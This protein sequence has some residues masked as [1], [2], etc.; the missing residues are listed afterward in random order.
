[1]IPTHMVR[2][3]PSVHVPIAKHD[4]ARGP[5]VIPDSPNMRGERWPGC[6]VDQPGYACRRAIH[7]CGRTRL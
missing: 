3:S 5:S 2:S 7:R 4:S 6:R 1:M